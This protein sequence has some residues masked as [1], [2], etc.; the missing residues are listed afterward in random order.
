M[1]SSFEPKFIGDAR[2]AK[3]RRAAVVFSDKVFKGRSIKRRSAH[4]PPPPPPSS[5][6]N[7]NNAFAGFD[8]A[9]FNT[10][11]PIGAF[12][13]PVDDSVFESIQ[14]T[15]VSDEELD[16]VKVAPL[17]PE[18]FCEFCGKDAVEGAQCMC[19]DSAF[20]CSDCGHLISTDRHSTCGFGG[21]HCVQCGLNECSCAR[22]CVYCG[23]NSAVSHDCASSALIR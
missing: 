23:M 17:M 19:S 15:L 12:D 4:T 22:V 13:E 3:K 8:L 5:P 11:Y 10:M 21:T 7:K 16:A 9:G 20:Y 6:D 2:E 14:H 18:R 1:R